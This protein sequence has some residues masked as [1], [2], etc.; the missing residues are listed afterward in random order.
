MEVYKMSESDL[1]CPGCSSFSKENSPG[2]I[3]R[4]LEKERDDNKMICKTC[5]KE[6]SLD[7]IKDNADEQG[8]TQCPGCGSR[9]KA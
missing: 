8:Y 2:C 4:D 6:V 3:F 5:G 7:Y 1:R 9:I